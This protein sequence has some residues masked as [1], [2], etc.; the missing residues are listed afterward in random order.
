MS[1][2]AYDVGKSPVNAH[3]HDAASWSSCSSQRHRCQEED[4]HTFIHSFVGLERF[5]RTARASI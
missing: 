2:A 4:F 5:G 3:G 1:Y